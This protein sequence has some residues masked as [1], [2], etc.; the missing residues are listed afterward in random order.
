M[1]ASASAFGPTG[2]SS[3][4]NPQIALR[5]IDAS[6]ATA[7]TSDWYRSAEFGNLEA[8]TGL[9]IDMGHRVRI[10]SV[11]II[12]GSARGADLRL[13]TG[14]VPDLAE[15]RLKAAVND[16]D[17]SLHLRLARPERA[18]YL[19]IWFTLLPPDSSGT[20]QISVY[21]VRLKGTR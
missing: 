5:A 16:A 11:L 4:D 19:L 9:L 17:G 7:W 13:L 10:T 2:Y 14:N 20:F 18:R 8:G 15:L 21:D 6:T 3:G 1:P 12:L